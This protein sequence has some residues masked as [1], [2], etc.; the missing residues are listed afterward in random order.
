M[1]IHVSDA[2]SNPN[3]QIAHAASVLRRSKRRTLVFTAI[4]RGKTKVKTVDELAKATRLG[5]VAVLQAGGQLANQQIV[6][7]VK[8]RGRTAYEKDRFYGT[9]K[10]KILRLAENP[11]KLRNFP[12]KYSKTSVQRI[13]IVRPQG[14]K[15][16]VSEVKCDDFDEFA[17]V[18]RIRKAPAQIVSEST[19]KKGIQKLTGET[20]KFQDW[21]GER[22]DLYTS[23]IRLR[24]KRRSIAF[25]F[26]GPGTSGVLTPRKLGKHGN[27]IQRLFLSPAEIYVV[28][29]CGQIHEDILEQMNTFATAKS[30]RENKQVWYAVIDGD[31]TNRLL[32]AYP[33][34][35]GLN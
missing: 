8:V 35:F 16:Q 25:A 32:Q 17:K 29:Y 5:K 34:Q 20:G 21:G 15:I 30:V 6:T 23:K 2:R 10:K 19:F 14:V 1:P 7:Q 26:K 11:D 9:N 12:T 22:N 27:Q 3:D 31:D 18:R 33:R 28:Q 13:S 4:Y 24:G